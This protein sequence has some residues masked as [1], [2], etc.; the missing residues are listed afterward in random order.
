MKLA[1]VSKSRRR[2]RPKQSKTPK[3]RRVA[4][5]T[6]YR[7]GP[8]H[9]PRQYQWP[10]GTSGNPKGKQKTL[11]VAPDLRV[12]LERALN[13]K[14]KGERDKMVTKAAAGIDQLVDQFAKGDPRAR[15][16]LILL[17]EKLG[18]DLTNRKTLEGAL[19]DALSAED[20]ALLADFV[21]RHGGQYPLRTDGVAGVVARDANLLGPPIDDPKLLSAPPENSTDP[22]SEEQS[23]E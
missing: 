11:S 15:R 22:Q 2:R 8:G 3:A 23:H 4:A 20:E 14:I 21:R 6:R 13:A 19:E 16:D 12:L 18:V 10:K 7:V 5:K 9:P 17:G 1:I